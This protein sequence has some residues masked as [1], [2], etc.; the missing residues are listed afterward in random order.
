MIDCEKIGMGTPPKKAAL[1]AM[2]I[3]ALRGEDAEGMPGARITR[4]FPDGPA[5]K[6]GL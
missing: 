5:E 3:S 6:A 4:L 1:Q 2:P